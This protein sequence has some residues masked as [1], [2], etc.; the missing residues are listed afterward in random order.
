MTVSYPNA[1]EPLRMATYRPYLES[2]RSTRPYPFYTRY[3]C[4]RGCPSLPEAQEAVTCDTNLA[5]APIYAVHV[6][7]IWHSVVS[8]YTPPSTSIVGKTCAPPPKDEPRMSLH[9]R[10]HAFTTADLV[11]LIWCAFILS[12]APCTESRPVLHATVS[13]LK[14]RRLRM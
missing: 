8:H 6:H 14:P 12:C 4:P 1:R 5:C 11:R 10:Y 3:R 7:H 13:V 2:Q 9:V